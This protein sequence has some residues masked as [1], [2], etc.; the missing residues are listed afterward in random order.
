MKKL[1]III[2]SMFTLVLLFG[3]SNKRQEEST[4]KATGV[5][6]S[7]EKRNNVVVDGV[8]VL[9]SIKISHLEPGSLPDPKDA[10]TLSFAVTKNS[11]IFLT[12][13][14]KRSAVDISAIQKG[15]RA[16]VTWGFAN[17]HLTEAIEIDLK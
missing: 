3:C 7:V 6:E 13:D 11:V 8:E 1:A 12:T 14:D 17:D 15:Q 9:Y 4:Y 10:S 2:V 5:I 16:E